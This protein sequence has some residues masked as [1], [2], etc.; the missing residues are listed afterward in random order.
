MAEEVK[1]DASFGIEQAHKMYRYFQ[2]VENMIHNMIFSGEALEA[3][4][5]V[6]VATLSLKAGMLT[7]LKS[8]PDFEARKLDFQKVEGEFDGN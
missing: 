7:H 8:H 5:A 4:A 3:V 2:D 1:Q 6:K